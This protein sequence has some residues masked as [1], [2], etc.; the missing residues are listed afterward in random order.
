MNEKDI[1]D[2]RPF[3]AGDHR[4]EAEQ[5]F[6][7]KETL[8]A[9]SIAEVDVRRWSTSCRS[10]RSSWRCRTRNSCVRR[11]HAGVVGQLLRSI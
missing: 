5:R 1:A 10:T 7:D 8:P 3:Q 4:R 11:R 2:S 9:Q 6:R